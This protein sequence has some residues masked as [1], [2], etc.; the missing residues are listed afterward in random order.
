MTQR[1]YPRYGELVVIPLGQACYGYGQALREPEIAFFDL[2]SDGA[3]L[4]AAEVEGTAVAFRLWV[5]RYGPLSWQK[6]G[7]ASLP[8]GLQADVPR[9]KQDALTSKFSIYLSGSE[10]PASREEV[11]GLECAAVWDPSHVVDRL[12]DHFAGRL[13]KW[14]QS[15]LPR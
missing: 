5:Q 13:N 14:H 4:N 9:F 15:F 3:V 6:L 11:E 1:R 10:R 8:P 12:N 2:R 7:V